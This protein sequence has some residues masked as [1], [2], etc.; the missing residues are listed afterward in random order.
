[1]TSLNRHALPALAASPRSIREK[2]SFGLAVFPQFYCI[3]PLDM[4]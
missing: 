3:G 2:C 1:M 4:G